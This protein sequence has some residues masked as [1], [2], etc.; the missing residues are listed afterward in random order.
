MG[1]FIMKKV[2]Y[3][4][5][6][7][8]L[9]VGLVLGTVVHEA[10]AEWEP[11][12]PIKLIVPWGAGGS[13]DRSARTTVGVIEDAWGQKVVVVNQPGA[14]GSVGTKGCLDAPRDG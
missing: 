2:M 7:M 13:T 14:S 4:V 8:L 3:G 12:K 5:T 10:N 9:C 11:K 6:L 1:V